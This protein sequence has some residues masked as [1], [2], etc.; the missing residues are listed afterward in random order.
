MYSK[1]NSR[2]F[3]GKAFPC[4]TSRYALFPFHMEIG[5]DNGV[6]VTIKDTIYMF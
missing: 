1:I 4:K 6:K 3:F 2:L 5:V